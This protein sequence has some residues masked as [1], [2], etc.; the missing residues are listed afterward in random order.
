MSDSTAR[1]ALLPGAWYLNKDLKGLIVE[2]TQDLLV[3]PSFL[4]NGNIIEI[5]SGP[6][7]LPQAMFNF[8]DCGRSRLLR[9]FESR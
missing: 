5:I 4:K 6:D 1:P 3:T 2:F 8:T 9:V 7:P